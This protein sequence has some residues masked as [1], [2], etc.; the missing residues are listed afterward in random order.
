[1]I[2]FIEYDS[3]GNI[4]HVCADPVATI[5]PLVNRVIFNGA[6]G[7]P[8]KDSSGNALSVFNLPLADPAGITAGQYQTLMAGGVE[9]FTYNPTMQNVSAKVAANGTT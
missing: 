1:L 3:A 9:N 2:Y 7:L 4:C 8:L 6:D 5:V